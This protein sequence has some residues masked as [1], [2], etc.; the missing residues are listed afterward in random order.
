MATVIPIEHPSLA[1][2]N[3]VAANVMKPVADIASWQARID[4]AQQKLSSY[5]AMKHS[6]SM[7]L[8]ELLDMEIDVGDV[9]PRL[10]E[11][12]Q[13]IKRAATEYMTTR[14]AAEAAIQAAREALAQVPASELID[15]PIDFRASTLSYLPLSSD[16]LKLDA[17]YFSCGDENEAAVAADIERFVRESVGVHPTRAAE[18]AKDAGAQAHRQLT[19]NRVAGTL[20]ITASCSHRNVAVFEPLILDPDKAIAAW[21]RVHPDNLLQSADRGQ[22]QQAAA[23][24][25]ARQSLPLVTG[26]TYGSS[27][28]GMVHFLRASS[29]RVDVSDDLAQ[30]VQERLRLGGWLEYASGNF[31]VDRGALDE[32]RKLLSMEC[33]SAH[34]SVICTGALPTIAASAVKATLDKVAQASPKTEGG[35]SVTSIDAEAQQARKLNQAANLQAAHAGGLL[36]ALN[37]IDRAANRVLDVNSLL[38]A[39]ENYLTSVRQSGTGVPIGFHIRHLSKR[40]IATLWLERNVT[41]KLAAIATIPLAVKKIS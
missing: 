16:S 15:S 12:D 34:I 1:I 39:F 35:D 26:V 20:V 3:I 4:G 9:Q 7:L 23:E 6:L 36:R 17:Q 40:E 10:E 32:V 5:L 8:G 19:N 25:E 30:Q 41:E 33:V 28:V 13:A 18:L 29:A 31:G 27:F 24:D 11:T 22:M 38:S 21:N 2:G 37:E 14:L